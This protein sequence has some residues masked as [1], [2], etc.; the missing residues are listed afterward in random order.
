MNNSKL[1]F[2]DFVKA[3]TLPESREEIQGIAYLVF[4]NLLG[5]S[6]A[7]I[8]AEKTITVSPSH[9]AKLRD[10]VQR[11]NQHEPVQYVLGEADFFGRKFQ[12]SPAV[13][14][15][16][17]ET[18]ELVRLIIDRTTTDEPKILDIG[19][20]SGCIPITLALEIAGSIVYATDVSTAA[21][22]VAKDNAIKLNARV[23]FME[24][25]ILKEEL[26][27]RALDVVV[28]N[29]PYI[30]PEE[31]RDMKSNVVDHEPHLALFT[32]VDD[33]LIF[34]RTIVNKAK[35]AL[36]SGGLLCM[37]INERYGEAVL[38]LLTAAGY[39]DVQIIKDLSGKDRIVKGLL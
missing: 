29:P 10:A 8:L 22:A 36:R 17:P 9:E 12:V 19:T 32:P 31:Q 23:T 24:H 13:L 28:S 15:P 2:Y 1:L 14:I 30:A 39:K 37:E 20:G 3:I 26:T 18:E 6:K 16:R 11:I 38:E 5:L 34:Y 7:Q 35:A 33:P 25:D 21:L 27:L 4:E